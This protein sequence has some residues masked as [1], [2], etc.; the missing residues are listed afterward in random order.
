M[1]DFSIVLPGNEKARILKW[2]I[3]RDTKIGAGA[4]LGLYQPV[5]SNRTLKLKC[6]KVG[7]VKELVAKEGDLVKP[8][9][10]VLVAKL[11]VAIK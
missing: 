10:V 1:A 5:N 4:V 6:A 3:T 7:T 11:G 8:G 9:Y 2:K